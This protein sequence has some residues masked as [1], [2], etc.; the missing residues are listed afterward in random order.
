MYFTIYKITNK[1]NGKTYIGK[2]KTFN[3]N[4]GYMGSGKHL[5]FSQQK[6]GIE[7]FIKEILFVFDNENDMNKKEKELVTLEFCLREDTYNICLGG[8]GGYNYINNNKLNVS[9][10]E[11][12]KRNPDLI[13]KASEMGNEAKNIK[14]KNDEIWANKYKENISKSLKEYNAKNPNPFKGKFHTDEWKAR[15]SEIMSQKQK[16]SNNS[17]FGTSWIT[18]GI[19]NKKIK[20]QVDIIPEGWYNGRTIK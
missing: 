7:N 17:Q 12:I 18:N 9:I 14:L 15:Q 8:N 20:K 13:R 11:Q 2:H 3:I 16:G 10:S 4:D 5:K 19:D 6:Y 1:I